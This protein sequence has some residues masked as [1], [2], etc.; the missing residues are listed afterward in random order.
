VHAELRAA[1]EPSDGAS[2]TEQLL[3]K[4]EGAIADLARSAA[5]ATVSC[6]RHPGSSSPIS[7]P[8]TN[9]YILI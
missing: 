4:I 6:S 5:T 2:K 8:L 7:E 9:I 3:G 1:R